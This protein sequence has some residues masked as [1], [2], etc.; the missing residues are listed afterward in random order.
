MYSLC[1]LFP[2]AFPSSAP[3][4]VWCKERGLGASL[5]QP[6]SPLLSS[7]HACC[8]AFLPMH[9]DALDPCARSCIPALHSCQVICIP[10][11]H[12]CPASLPGQK[13]SCLD[14]QILALDPLIPAPAP[15]HSCCPAFLPMQPHLCPSVLHLCASDLIPAWVRAS[16]PCFPAALH[17][18]PA[19]LSCIPALHPCPA[20]ALCSGT[21]APCPQPVSLQRWVWLQVPRLMAAPAGSQGRWLW[22][23]ASCGNVQPCPGNSQIGSPSRAAQSWLCRQH[24][25]EVFISFQLRLFHLALPISDVPAR[26]QPLPSRVFLGVFSPAACTGSTGGC[27]HRL[28]VPAPS[29]VFQPDKGSLGGP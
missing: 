7:L 3:C 18:C 25:A 22:G 11:L 29:E 28:R 13:N 23:G 20:P 14:S 6:P 2:S 9:L 24:P 4:W 26:I 27:G 8:P 10:T 21:A 17:P 15:L 19:S 5:L 1:Q 12:P 16:L